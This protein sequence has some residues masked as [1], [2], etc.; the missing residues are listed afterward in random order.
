MLLRWSEFQTAIT[1]SSKFSR[2]RSLFCWPLSSSF[3]GFNCLFQVL[4]YNV[5]YTFWDF[6]LKISTFQSREKI[7]ESFT[8]VPF[9]RVCCESSCSFQSFELPHQS[10][11]N[12]LFS[13][14]S[15][16]CF[17]DSSVK[18]T[19]WDDWIQWGLKL[20]SQLRPNKYRIYDKLILG[21]VAFLC[22]RA[23]TNKIYSVRG[24]WK[25]WLQLT[26]CLNV[27]SNRLTTKIQ[28]SWFGGQIVVFRRCQFALIL[29]FW[30][31]EFPKIFPVCGST[32]K[33]GYEL[34]TRCTTSTKKWIN[35]H[36]LTLMKIQ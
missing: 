12:P 18:L 33:V 25:S 15:K 13:D 16:H 23:Q 1:H 36:P 2:T 31:F 8:S 20:A 21:H 28:I 4:S 19:H 30:V 9:E 14:F 24:H 17:S 7:L 22:V 27:L 26:M 6:Q 32:F 5:E 35:R 3:L 34:I 11:N 10:P 29:A